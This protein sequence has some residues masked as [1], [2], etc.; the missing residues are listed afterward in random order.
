MDESRKDYDRSLKDAGELRHGWHWLA[1]TLVILVAVCV[2]DPHSIIDNPIGAA[3]FYSLAGL[4]ASPLSHLV[5]RFF[6]EPYAWA[7]RKLGVTW[8]PVA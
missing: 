2:N 6:P 1:T 3:V 7:A 4:L 8:Q 5:M